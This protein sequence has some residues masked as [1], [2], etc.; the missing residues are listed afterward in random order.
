MNREA[1]APFSFHFFFLF[2]F[3]F[4]FGCCESCQPGCWYTTRNSFQNNAVK[5]KN[6]EL[7]RKHSTTALCGNTYFIHQGNHHSAHPCVQCTHNN[8]MCKRKYCQYAAHLFGVFYFFYFFYFIF[9]SSRGQWM[10]LG[11]CF[12]Y[13]TPYTAHRPHSEPDHTTI[14][15]RVPSISLYPLAHPHT[16]ITCIICYE[17]HPCVVVFFFLFSSILSQNDGCIYN[18]VSPSLPNHIMQ[19]KNT[20]CWNIM[21]MLYG[22]SD[23][24]WLKDDGSSASAMFEPKN[25][26]FVSRN[27][28]SAMYA[29]QKK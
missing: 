6:C 1:L 15:Y 29:G 28:G 16:F 26:I 2:S 14:L 17:T 8:I 5:V 22:I 25:C 13:I 3:Y 12:G 11:G 18:L 19:K 7:F 23:E 9:C 24:V 10:W 27:W 20:K 21:N 4:F